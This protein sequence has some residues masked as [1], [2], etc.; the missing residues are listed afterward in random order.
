MRQREDERKEMREN[1]NRLTFRSTISS[2]FRI[3][4]N[5]SRKIRSPFFPG[6]RSV[7]FCFSFLF[8]LYFFK[9]VYI[10]VYFSLWKTS[11]SFIEKHLRHETTVVMIMWKGIYLVS[12]FL[13][14]NTFTH[15]HIHPHARTR[16]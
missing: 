5:P 9:S 12:L 8:F 1:K 2:T 14:P 10:L 4:Q 7:L 16:M 11:D 13:K 15:K 3:I 6:L